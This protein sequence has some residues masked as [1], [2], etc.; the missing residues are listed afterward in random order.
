MGT[1]VWESVRLTQICLQNLRFG[2]CPVDKQCV[3]SN[4]R[5]NQARKVL[6][7]AMAT[8]VVAAP[9]TAVV[10]SAT[11]LAA[12]AAYNGTVYGV[13]YTN[14]NVYTINTGTGVATTPAIG[15]FTFQS[16]G[17]ARQP[18]TNLIYYTEYKASLG[19]TYRIGTFNI[20]TGA[21]ATLGTASSAYLPRLGF[22]SDGTLW[23]ME[24]NSILHQVNTTTGAY[25][26]GAITLTNAGTTAMTGAGGDIAFAPDGT[27]YI[28]SGTDVFKAIP[29]AG[30]YST[31][32]F[33]GA[34][35][36]V[37][38]TISGIEF[39]SGGTLLVSV[40]NGVTSS[41]H[42][43]NPSTGVATAV[44]SVGGGTVVIADLTVLP[45][46]PP[47]AVNDSIT[48]P[49]NTA[50]TVTVKANDSDPEA[51]PL[52]V[53][54]VTNGTNG[55]VAI[56]G[57]NPV[58]TP[59]P[60][61]HGTDTFT[62][63]ISD[64]NGGTATATVTVTVQNRPPVA[65]NDSVSTPGNTAVT[66]AVLT[67]DSDPNGDTLTVTS[68]TTGTNGT[69]AIVGGLPVYTPN[70][71]FRGVDTF[72]YT[73]SDGQGGNA[74]ATVTVTVANRPPV[75]V[76]DSV[77][78]PVN[79]AITVSVLTNDS[80]PN[81][82]PVTVTAVTNGVHGTVTIVSGSPVFTPTAGYSGTDSFTYTISDGQGG[83]A[84]ATVNVSIKPTTANDSGTTAA[85]IVLNGTTV[86]ANDV[87][88]GLTVTANGAPAHGTVTV[89]ANGTYVYTPTA[90]YSGPD[91][92]TYTAT[93]SAG[94]TSAATVN[95]IVTPRAVDN[96]GTTP[97]GTA[98]SGASVLTNDF[99]SG[100][101]VTSNI[102]PAHGTV[103]IA[104]NG[105][106]TYTPAAG[107]SGPDSFTY[108]ATDA[109]GRTT[110]A[111]VNL[112]VTPV[113]VNNTGVTNANVVLN[114]GSVIANDLGS[115][116]TVT[117]NTA[118]LHGTVTVAA[119]GT[120]VYTPTANYTGPDSFTYTVTDGSGQTATATVNITV[121]PGPV[122][123]SGTT[124]ANTAL[125]GSTVLSN[126]VGT[127]L[128]VTANT[129]PAHGT[130]TIASNGTYTYTPTTGYSGP[131]SFT[132]TV[133]DSLGNTGT[134]TVNLT[135]TPRAI[136]DAASTPAGTTLRT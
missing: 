136:T 72:T 108:T 21:N 8:A 62:Y 91:G 46:L 63:T 13:D 122:N 11:E 98:L 18:G 113:A 67:N 27:M 17:I 90:G 99:G 110:T 44:G 48:T 118:P 38:G 61:F 30:V 115:T 3:I 69:V 33:V 47:V 10:I 106:Y 29:S 124:P 103:T 37:A 36:I 111:T 65:V 42:S 43:I 56:V 66:V 101:S 55:T 74:T 54:S 79:T 100:L 104:S 117:S 53:T 131:D 76:T 25:I 1:G 22:R 134:A 89:A 105:T 107:Y 114:G 60:T 83:T 12:F 51:D 94:S 116:L 4:R 126:D 84:T 128:S 9:L 102:A 132:Y 87:G 96:V 5:K 41:L 120:Y 15:T 59:N 23:A 16:A 130:V 19:G 121:G 129:A 64:G 97:A 77:T 31:Y 7:S 71:A 127:G 49:G 95:L 26:V 39:G 35:G 28:V 125:T 92:F 24:G 57:G 50:V 70:A 78:T 81:G 40:I 68:V 133:T 14:G 85:G 32:T 112:T 6:S 20:S 80:D 86:L 93:D 52:T 45:D 2:L 135:V 82:D 58:Y 123:D 119:I 73:I 75:A 109:S 88:T 34:S